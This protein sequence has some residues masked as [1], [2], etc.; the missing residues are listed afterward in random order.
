MAAMRN[1]Y[2]DFILNNNQDSAS[3]SGSS[4][5]EGGGGGRGSL[6]SSI[7]SSSPL[8][9]F[10]LLFHS[11]APS[12]IKVQAAASASTS[13]EL[14][15]FDVMAVADMD[16]HSVTEH[17]LPFRMEGGETNHT[18]HEH[19]LADGWSPSSVLAA[20]GWKKKKKNEN[21]NENGV[22]EVGRDHDKSDGGEDKIDR[23]SKSKNAS[24][25]DQSSPL[26]SSSSPSPI[27]L[28]WS[29][30]CGNGV[31]EKSGRLYDSFALEPKDL[32]HQR[33]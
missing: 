18:Y 22:K 10:S 25:Q 9:F 24:S 3:S 32:G 12:P 26:P 5:R 6:S 16:L 2:L 15:S 4:D 23:R 13:P 14:S 8:N 31:V 19:S 27:S 20:F 29:V 17:F 1:I 30:A 33:G 7:V 28:P 21:E 11:T